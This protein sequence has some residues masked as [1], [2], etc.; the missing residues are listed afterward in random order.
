MEERERAH[1]MLRQAQKMEAVG[2]LAG[3]VAHDFNNLLTAVTMN[4]AR[5]ERGLGEEQAGARVAIAN[6]GGRAPGRAAHLAASVLCASAGVEA[7]SARPDGGRP[8]AAAA[9]QRRGG[10]PGG[11]RDRGGGDCVALLDRNQLESAIINLAV[12]ARDAMPEGGRVVI[13]TRVLSGDTAAIE[14]Q[15]EGGEGMPED[16]RKRAV[17]P[18]FTTKP[19]GRG[20][21]LGLSQV[22]GFA[23]QSQGELAIES[24]PGRGTL[25]RLT[26]P[27]V[28]AA[29]AEAAG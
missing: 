6:A 26:F 1:D 18:F 27:L 8:A 22:L 7:G 14:V 15:D 13:R 28:P 12:N 3:G 2:Q 20:S 21:G 16:V 23:Q 24:E 9:R 25:V 11:D 4:L 10:R 17:E 29:S 19:V 5:A